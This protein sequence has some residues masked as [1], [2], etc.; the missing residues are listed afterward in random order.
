MAEALIPSTSRGRI[1]DE[2][3]TEHII[4][5]AVNCFSLSSNI[6]Q[7]TIQGYFIPVLLSFS[8]KLDGGKI[9]DTSVFKDKLATEQLEYCR[10]IFSEAKIIKI[11]SNLIPEDELFLYLRKFNK[12]NHLEI[13]LNDDDM[14]TFPIGRFKF[15]TLIIK[16]FDRTMW[17]DPVNAILDHNLAILKRFSLENGYISDRTL[18]NLAPNELSV[19][20]LTD[21]IINTDNDRASL[22]KY[23][24]RLKK[25]QT[26]KVIF[27][28][29]II[30]LNSFN[31]FFEHLIKA[32]QKPLTH[33]I[34]LS[35]SPDA[36]V[37]NEVYDFKLFPSL[38]SL[39]IYYTTE[40]SFTN[41]HNII[42]AINKARIE[43][44]CNPANIQF[45]EFFTKSL[46]YA[47]KEEK[48]KIKTRSKKFQEQ[49]CELN[50]KYVL[51]TPLM[52]D[53]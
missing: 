50:Q 1:E 5:F 13:A 18:L 20:E 52:H 40:R 44:T 45:I 39:E 27:T 14:F 31:H 48:E 7:H 43:K 33:L 32:I 28:K 2:L 29:P 42:G 17:A 38:M 19:L 34:S 6:N 47:S 15:E 25:L 10:N 3:I 51:I 35:F 11:N 37:P 8:K 9:F 36:E 53:F 49:I 46:V 22:I 24:L 30:K 41:I 26:L 12:A 21:I 16:C 23:I 4:N